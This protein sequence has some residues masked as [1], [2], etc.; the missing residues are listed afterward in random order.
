MW[1]CIAPIRCRARALFGKS[2]QK[3][4]PVTSDLDLA[5]IRGGLRDSYKG[6]LAM[7][8]FS[9]LVAGR[10]RLARRSR[11]RSRL[12]PERCAL[13]AGGDFDRCGG[14]I[15]WPEVATFQR[16]GAMRYWRV[17]DIFRTDVLRVENRRSGERGGGLYADVAMS[18]VFG[19]KAMP[20]HNAAGAGLDIAAG[21]GD[22]RADLEAAVRFEIGQ[23]R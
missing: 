12:R 3:P 4:G 7:L 2:T 20:D 13:C 1:T 23:G 21:R 11:M 10:F 18:G 8:A 9:A 17:C 19:W 16:P 22:L 6:H 5:P 14:A 15:G